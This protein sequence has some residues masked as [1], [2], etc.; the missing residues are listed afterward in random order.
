M[1]C[2]DVG[3]DCSIYV[4]AGLGVKFVVWREMKDDDADRN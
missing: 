3:S 1:E 2:R 4:V